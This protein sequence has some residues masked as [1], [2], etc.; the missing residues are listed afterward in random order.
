MYQARQTELACKELGLEYV[1][2][3]VN[4]S[5]EVKAAAQSLMGRVDAIY[6]STD[7]TVV[8]P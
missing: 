8:S 6:V 4:S 5:A 1:A 2:T 3:A 7:N